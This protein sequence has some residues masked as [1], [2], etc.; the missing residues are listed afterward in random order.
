MH[1]HVHA[2][3][4]ACTCAHVTGLGVLSKA[5]KEAT[6]VRLFASHVNPAF[7]YLLTLFIPLG[8]AL[9]GVHVFR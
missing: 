7:L 2:R 3:I 9:D 4:C 5:R 8:F 1:A 6:F